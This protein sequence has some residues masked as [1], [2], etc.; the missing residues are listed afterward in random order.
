MTQQFDDDMFVG[1][2]NEPPENYMHNHLVRKVLY[3]LT[4][5]E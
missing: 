2:N 3:L 1:N 4:L 5:P